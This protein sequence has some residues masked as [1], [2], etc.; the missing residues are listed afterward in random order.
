M[1][2]YCLFR[3]F[4]I[5][6]HFTELGYTVVNQ[7]FFILIRIADDFPEKVAHLYLKVVILAILAELAQ[8]LELFHCDLFSWDLPYLR[9]EVVDMVLLKVE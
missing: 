6:D 3:Q 8:T 4:P 2:K 5:F 9:K 7:V 1:E